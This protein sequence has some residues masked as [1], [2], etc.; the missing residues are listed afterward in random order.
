MT[1]LLTMRSYSL[2]CP[3]CLWSGTSQPLPLHPSSW[4]G[5][6]WALSPWCASHFFL[7]TSHTQPHGA[8][9]R[10]PEG[11]PLSGCHECP[12]A[13]RGC[14][15]P[16]WLRHRDSVPGSACWAVRLTPLPLATLHSAPA[17]SS[18]G[19]RMTLLRSLISCPLF[20]LCLRA[21]HSHVSCTGSFT[22]SIYLMP[23]LLIL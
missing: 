16:F 23:K 22:N 19:W 21:P 12:E 7:I 4:Q 6:K 17:R 3:R 1:F 9:K 13:G 14:V 20:I 8:G 18:R 15:S 10:S 11:P 5:G 2:C